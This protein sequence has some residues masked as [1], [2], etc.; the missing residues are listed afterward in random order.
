MCWSSMFFLQ[1]KWPRCSGWRKWKSIIF[2]KEKIRREEPQNCQNK[3]SYLHHVKYILRT[4]MLN[5]FMVANSHQFFLDPDIF[6]QN[7]SLWYLVFHSFLYILWCYSAFQ[8]IWVVIH[9]KV[10]DIT[11]FLDEVRI[12]DCFLPDIFLNPDPDLLNPGSRRR[13]FMTEKE[14]R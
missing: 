8:S 13:F 10:Y 14:Y 9:D 3:T 2:L 12:I 1:I 11:K 5:L 6:V 4:R 7:P